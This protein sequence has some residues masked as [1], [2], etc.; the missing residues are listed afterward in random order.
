MMKID[1]D[2]TTRYTAYF[3]IPEG[4]LS[5][6]DMVTRA[7]IRATKGKT[8]TSGYTYLPFTSAGSVFIDMLINTVATII[9]PLALSLLL[10]VFLYLIVLEK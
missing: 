2:N 9:F 3:I 4:F 5:V 7:Y 8:V 1:D 10:P 6:M